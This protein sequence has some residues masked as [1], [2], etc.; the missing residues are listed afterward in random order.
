MQ[1]KE[2]YLTCGKFP[3]TILYIIFRAYC[4]ALCGMLCYA[5]LVI[6][7]PEKLLNSQ[8]DNFTKH[9]TEYQNK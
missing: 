4:I 8:P 3:S 1:N 2:S 6:I 5:T 7:L 9:L